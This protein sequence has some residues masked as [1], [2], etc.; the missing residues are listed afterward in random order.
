MIDQ[1][2]QVFLE[3]A[4]FGFIIGFVTVFCPEAK[5]RAKTFYPSKSSLGCATL[6]PGLTEDAPPELE[7][8]GFIF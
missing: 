1:N 3:W 2:N 8:L 4:K 6:H 7:V 5:T